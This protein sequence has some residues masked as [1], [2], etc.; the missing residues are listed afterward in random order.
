MP[1]RSSSSEDAVTAAEGKRYRKAIDDMAEEF[2][3]PIT[4]ELPLE[5]VIAEDGRIYEKHAIEEWFKT[6]RGQGI[7]SPVANE[8]MGTRLLP[9]TQARNAIKNMVESGAITGAKADAW[10]Q[11]IRDEAK[12][13]D[14]RQRA[15]GGDVEAMCQLFYVYRD[16]K[17]GVTKDH[18]QAFAWAKRA[19]DAKGD[20]PNSLCLL[21]ESYANGHGTAVNNSLSLLYI[22]QAAVLGSEWACCVLACWFEH[23]IKGLDKDLSVAAHWYGKMASCTMKD[24]A[25]WQRERAD[26]FLREH[27]QY[28]T[29]D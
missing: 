28:R 23:G 7:K 22:G 6:R 20:D 15:E 2:L 1:K 27:P 13:A 18:T 14:F 12:V 3:C 24:G 9:G 25:P 10:H 19:M 4:Q 17:Y 21:A 11:R 8:P 16:G 26:K 29:V 5:P